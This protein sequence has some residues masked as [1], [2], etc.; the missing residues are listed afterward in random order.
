[1][2]HQVAHQFQR[3]WTQA[4]WRVQRA[5]SGVRRAA[6][7]RSASKL[8]TAGRA[9][10]RSVATAG[11]APAAAQTAGTATAGAAT[12]GARHRRC[13]GHS[14]APHRRQ[15]GGRGREP[16]R[17][18]GTRRPAC[19]RHAAH[20]RGRRAGHHREAWARRDSQPATAGWSSRGRWW[21]WLSSPATTPYLEFGPPS[22]GSAVSRL[23]SQAG[24]LVE[25]LVAELE[26][27]VTDGARQG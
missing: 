26:T 19:R 24:S 9:A 25:H 11:A 3:N 13:R 10:A 15:P 5:T 6:T 21:T 16:G 7:T 2:V 17:L 12:A 8:P 23:P 22:V 14:R 1:M 18:A 27:A 20:G 4:R